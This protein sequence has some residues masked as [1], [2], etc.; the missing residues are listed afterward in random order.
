MIFQ[1]W[2]VKA[3]TQPS[4]TLIAGD[5]P[6]CL[7]WVESRHRESAF[8]KVTTADGSYLIEK[9]DW[10]SDEWGHRSVG[11]REEKGG[12]SMQMGAQNTS[13]ALGFRRR[14]M[15]KI[16]PTLLPCS[17]YSLPNI[18]LI[19]DTAFF[20]LLLLIIIKIQKSGMLPK[21]A[22]R[23]KNKE[24]NDVLCTPEIFSVD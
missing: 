15:E 20:S 7:F 9:E 8:I 19:W 6:P 21:W 22:C 5:G 10:L 14:T 23:K 3:G 2:E 13:L 4:G 11:S 18:L 24:R 1:W 12:A 16:W 17:L